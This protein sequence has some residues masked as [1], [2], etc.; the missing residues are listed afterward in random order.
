[1]KSHD[2]ALPALGIT[3]ISGFLLCVRSREAG[4][5][6]AVIVKGGSAGGLDEGRGMGKS[7]QSRETVREGDKTWQRLNRG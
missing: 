6:A 7:G 5:E 3:S 2:Q 1:M 4:E